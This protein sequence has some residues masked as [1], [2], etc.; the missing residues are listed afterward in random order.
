MT[1]S[2]FT[3]YLIISILKAHQAGVSVVDLYRKHGVGE[4][5]VYTWKGR[6]IGRTKVDMTT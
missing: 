4:A 1:R 3:V 6:L 5:T 2:R